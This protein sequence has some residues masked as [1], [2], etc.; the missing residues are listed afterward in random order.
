MQF[1]QTLIEGTF[2]SRTKRFVAEVELENGEAVSAHLANRGSM[3]GC[4]E[5]GSKVLLSVHD[6]PRRKFKHQLEIVYSGQVPVLVHTGR[7]SG[8]ITEALQAG[9]IPELAGY[10]EIRREVPCRDGKI[11]ILLEGNGLRPCY[12]DVYNVT[13]AEARVAQFPDAVDERLTERMSDLTD[14]V[15]EGNRAMVMFVATRADVDSFRPADAIDPEFSQAFRDA[16]AR[17]V[18]TLCYRANVTQTGIEL[19]ARLTMDLSE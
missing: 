4:S 9:L 19:D 15:R 8:V 11:S 2:K 13:L 12:I 17:G 3:L 10:G 1:E 18:E 16:V 7:P 6:D 5:P 14:L